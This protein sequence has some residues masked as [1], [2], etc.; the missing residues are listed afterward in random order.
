MNNISIYLT[1]PPTPQPGRRFPPSA[2]HMNLI[3]DLYS[4]QLVLSW[5]TWDPVIPARLQS[6]LVSVTPAPLRTTSP[7]SLLPSRP[8]THHAV[9]SL[10]FLHLLPPSSQVQPLLGAINRDLVSLQSPPPK[11]PNV[12]VR[13]QDAA[14]KPILTTL[15][16]SPE[17]IIINRLKYSHCG[18]LFWSVAPMS[19]GRGE[20][21]C[22]EARRNAPSTRS[23]SAGQDARGSRRLHSGIQSP[24]EDD[25]P[26]PG[27][28]AA[29]DSSGSAIS[30]Y[31]GSK[32]GGWGVEAVSLCQGTTSGECN[33]LRKTH[34]GKEGRREEGEG[35]I[36]KKNEK[37]RKKNPAPCPQV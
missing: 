22:H 33:S 34:G 36:Q 19:D 21:Q 15:C 37:K 23:E 11:R 14:H 10:S 29:G 6:T 7:F 16:S 1:P 25:P 4:E 28:S 5:K 35:G 2:F 18:V 24:A 17:R 32:G 9:P 27:G 3:G 26:D 12:P 8:K 31:S 30:P 20:A 13:A